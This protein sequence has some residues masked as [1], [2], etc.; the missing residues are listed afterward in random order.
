M[1]AMEYQT[2]ALM[3]WTLGLFF[4]GLSVFCELYSEIY[5]A[6]EDYG[7]IEYRYIQPYQ[8]VSGFLNV[9]AFSAVFAGVCLFWES[10]KMLEKKEV[11]K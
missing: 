4:L 10:H 7:W 1:K 5:Y 3:C 8:N 9:L 11:V 6:Y 2:L